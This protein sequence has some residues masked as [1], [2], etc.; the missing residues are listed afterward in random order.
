[1]NE[2]DFIVVSIDDLQALLLAADRDNPAVRE[3]YASLHPAVFEVLAQITREAAK[4]QKRVVLFGEGAADPV[5]IP[6][7]VGV[8]IRSFSVAPVR[9]K[10]M[11]QT[12]RKFTIDE[13]TKI[14]TELLKAPRALDVQRVLVQIAER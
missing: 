6:F 11:L 13:C 5:R 14:S 3:Y 9:L 2:S 8:G 10:M 4:H 12:L 1:M 7:Y